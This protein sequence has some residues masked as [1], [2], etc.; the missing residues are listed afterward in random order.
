MKWQAWNKWPAL[1]L[2]VTAIVLAAPPDN[3]LE[4]LT[5]AAPGGA[6]KSV[7]AQ[8]E[9]LVAV[10][11]QAVP[12]GKPMPRTGQQVVR[13]E[14]ERLR[15]AKQEAA[16]EEKADVANA[17]NVVSWYEPP[18]PPPPQGPQEPQEPVPEPAPVAPPLPFTYFGRYDDP[19]TRIV[20]LAR[21]G[22]IYPVSEGDV[23]DATYRVERI[24]DGAVSLVYLP[25]GTNQSI[26]MGAQ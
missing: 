11:P 22:Q 13:V 8:P 23:I 6:P 18:P 14:L 15:R 3:G 4:E 20:V 9:Q 5:A 19:P 12:H 17:F 24:A 25:L 21:G 26:S 1:G 16:A 10:P 2:A 7:S